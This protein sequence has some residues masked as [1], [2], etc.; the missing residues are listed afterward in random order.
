MPD[1]VPYLVAVGLDYQGIG[2]STSDCYVCREEY[3]LELQAGS[4]I[5]LHIPSESNIHDVLERYTL[6]FSTRD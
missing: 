6:K 3:V 5:K 2:Q 4:D 1:G